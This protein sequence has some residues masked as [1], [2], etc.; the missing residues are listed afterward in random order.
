MKTKLAALV[1]AVAGCVH[2]PARTSAPIVWGGD[3]VEMRT[4]PSG[5]TLDFDCAH[6]RIDGPLRVAKDGTFAGDGTYGAE[7]GG[8]ARR[9]EP[10]DQKARYSGKITRDL[11]TLRVVIEGQDS[12]GLE[13]QLVRN[14]PGNVRKCR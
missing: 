13:F 7:H 12:K 5:S 3:H 4:T 11:M 6:G 2:A 10:A 14:Q 9:D 8:P 1:L